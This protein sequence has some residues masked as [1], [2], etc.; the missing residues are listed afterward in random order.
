V[1]HLHFHSL[2]DGPLLRVRD[3]ACRAPRSGCGP[4]EHAGAPALI[5]P[6]RGVFEC[7]LHRRAV[8]ADANSLLLMRGGE[9]YRVSHPAEHGDDCTVLQ[10]DRAV[11]DEALPGAAAR[12]TRSVP[13]PAP[14]QYRLR[15]FH[16][17]LARGGHD[18]LQAEEAGLVLLAGVAPSAG[19]DAEAAAARRSPAVERARAFIASRPEADVGIGEVARAAHRSEFHLARRFRAELGTSMHRYRLQLRLALALE[20]LAG[21]E[22]DL[23]ALAVDLGFAHHSHFSASFRRV[24]G[25]TPARVR[26]T[27]TRARLAQ[28]RRI[29]TAHGAA[30][31]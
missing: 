12:T 26:A 2:F 4:E 3:V 21:G 10:F 15:L 6:R 9:T 13:L 8:V 14:L 16:H 5:F 29:L 11:L 31:R 28:L 22:G 17:A 23:A 19:V 25:Q 1:A 20:R 27:L 7:H 24:F 30:P 18:R